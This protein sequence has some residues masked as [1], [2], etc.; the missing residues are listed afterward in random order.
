MKNLQEFVHPCLN[1]TNGTLAMMLC[2]QSKLFRNKQF[3]HPMEA[4]RTIRSIQEWARA[5]NLDPS[6][7]RAFEV[8]LASFLL[9]FFND[10][11]P[12][13]THNQYSA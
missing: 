2:M 8:I 12:E 3:L 10:P 13:N 1:C 6:Q 11:D 4:N 9:T 7:K 5:A